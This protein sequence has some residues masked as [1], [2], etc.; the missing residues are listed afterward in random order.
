MI[1]AAVDRLEVFISQ[2]QDG[3]G[4]AT[5][6]KAVGAVREEEADGFLVGLSVK[7]GGR[8]LHFVVDHPLVR[9]L[10]LFVEGES[11]AFLAKIRSSSRTEGLKTPSR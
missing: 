2:V 9:G 4:V 1:E 6:V 7:R 3:L 8:P 10:P 11:P 5:R